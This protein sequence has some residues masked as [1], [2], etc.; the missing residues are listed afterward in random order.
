MSE[1]TSGPPLGAHI[2]VMKK[3]MEV[4]ERNA[5]QVLESTNLQTPKSSGASVTGVG[6]NLDIKG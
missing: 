5:L 3:A 4:Q 6:Q 1:I 2:E